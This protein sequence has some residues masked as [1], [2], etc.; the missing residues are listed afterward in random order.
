MD[1]GAWRAAVHGVTENWTWLSNWAN[2]HKPVC[3][4]WNQTKRTLLKVTAIWQPWE[5]ACLY[6]LGWDWIVL[7]ETQISMN[8]IMSYKKSDPENQY[9]LPK[10]IINPLQPCIGCSLRVHMCVCLSNNE[11]S[12]SSCEDCLGISEMGINNVSCVEAPMCAAISKYWFPFIPFKKES[13]E[14][15]REEGAVSVWI[16]I[17]ESREQRRIKFHLSV[18]WRRRLCKLSPRCIQCFLKH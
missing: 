9:F 8:R 6:K 11:T 10:N 12:L 5:S 13:H 14:V 2:T 1:S 17:G 4:C 3:C 16:L 15:Q 18:S 7:K